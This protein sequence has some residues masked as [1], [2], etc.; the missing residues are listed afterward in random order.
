MRTYLM[1]AP[2]Q[3][4]SGPVENSIV[5]RVNTGG[6]AKKPKKVFKKNEK[7]HKSK[8]QLPIHDL[9]METSRQGA[10]EQAAHWHRYLLRGSG[11]GDTHE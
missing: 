4:E 11:D 8:I 7:W 5:S 2:K 10:T 9:L 6:C 1:D 3:W